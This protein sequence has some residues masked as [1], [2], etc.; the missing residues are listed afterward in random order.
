VTSRSASLLLTRSK[1]VGNKSLV[2]ST[3]SQ[4]ILYIML[5]RT[6]KAMNSVV[7]L[8][9]SLVV[10]ANLSVATASMGPGDKRILKSNKKAGKKVK[11]SKEPKKAKSKSI[12]K[13]AWRYYENQYVHDDP[14]LFDGE[15]FDDEYAFGEASF[16]DVKVFDNDKIQFRPLC[17]SN[18]MCCRCS[19]KLGCDQPDGYVEANVNTG[20]GINFCSSSNMFTWAVANKPNIHPY[21]LKSVY[22]CYYRASRYK[23]TFKCRYY[24]TSWKETEHNIEYYG[25]NA[26]DITMLGTARWRWEFRNRCAYNWDGD[27]SCVSI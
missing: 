12:G 14:P 2:A 6:I 24:L 13:N 4:N 23:C 27:W 18:G 15:V 1:Y 19:T 8:F 7:M 26:G 21:I 22:G 16:G 10:F 20:A 17:N 5:R 11:I 9:F 3:I 25:S